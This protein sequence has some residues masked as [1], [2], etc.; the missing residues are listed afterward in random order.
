MLIA[1]ECIT[2]YSCKYADVAPEPFDSVKCLKH[3]KHVDSD[4]MC[5][6]WS[7][8]LELSY[9]SSRLHAWDMYKEVHTLKNFVRY[10]NDKLNLTNNSPT[11]IMVTL[12]LGH[13]NEGVLKMFFSFISENLKEYLDSDEK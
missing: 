2:C 11:E 5:D 13:S 7:I 1:K 4:F 3:K 10:F 12:L 8:N 6:D 9:K